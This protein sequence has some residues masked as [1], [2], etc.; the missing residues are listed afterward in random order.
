MFYKLYKCYQIA[1]NI[2]YEN[3]FMRFCW[4]FPFPKNQVMNNKDHDNYTESSGEP[5]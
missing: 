1:Q 3:M 5:T 2:T 4:Y